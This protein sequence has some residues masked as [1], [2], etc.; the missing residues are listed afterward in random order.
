MSG[1]SQAERLRDWELLLKAVTKDNADLEN[2]E[3]FRA[4][5]ERSF[6]LAVEAQRRRNAL[7]A[8]VQEATQQ[9]HR[10]FRSCAEAAI[11]LR[12]FVK[13]STL[14]FPAYAVDGDAEVA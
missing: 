2:V 4:A 10:A 3:P 11:M 9:M 13:A 5:L 12:C 7:L 1:T 14:R 6:E 8:A